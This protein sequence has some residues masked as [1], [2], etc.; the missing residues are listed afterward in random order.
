MSTSM[1]KTLNADLA[2]RGALFAQGLNADLAKVQKVLD[3]DVFG[4]EPSS[5]S[6]LS[7]FSQMLTCFFFSGTQSG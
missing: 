6:P 3:D 1:T 7:S 4:G 2:T 5:R